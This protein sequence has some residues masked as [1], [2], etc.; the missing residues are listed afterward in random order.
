MRKLLFT[1]ALAI[2]IFGCHVNKTE[3]VVSTTDSVPLNLE[4]KKDSLKTKNSARPVASTINKDTS[5]TP[6]P[7]SLN[8]FFDNSL[9][10]DLELQFDTI[11][12]NRFDGFIK[13]NNPSCSIAETG[14]IGRKDIYLDHYCN[15]ICERFLVETGTC[16]KLYLPN[17]YDAGILGIL[18]SPSCDKFIVYS[19]YDGK[20]FGNYYDHRAELFV[21]TITNDQGLKAIKPLYK[22]FAYDWSID[23]L[24][25]IDNNSIAIKIYEEDRWG[26]GS[27]LQYKYVK[28]VL[29]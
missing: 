27:G 29:K 20:D 11:S 28:A 2:V 23:K 6:C 4:V 16:K 1:V 24:T 18:P 5:S 12:K 13:K 3:N 26:D 14:F 10:A 21:L 25:W 9:F 22:F 8:T 7:D 19:S 15:D 17:D